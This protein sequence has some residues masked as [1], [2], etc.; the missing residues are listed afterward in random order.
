MVPVRR[1]ALFVLSSFALGAA[2]Q[3][4]GAYHYEV[5]ASGQPPVSKDGPLSVG[6]SRQISERTGSYIVNGHVGAAPAQAA[7]SVSLSSSVQ[8]NA[9]VTASSRSNLDLKPPGDLATVAGGAVELSFELRGTLEGTATVGGRAKVELLT[10]ES[11]DS[12]EANCALS[13][14]PGKDSRVCILSLKLPTNFTEKDLVLVTPELTLT[15]AVSVPGGPQLSRSSTGDDLFQ[16]ISFR[17]LNASGTQVTGFTLKGG[18]R[19]IDEAKPNSGNLAVAVEYY[20]PD[21]GLYFVT[22]NAEEIA[23]LDSGKTRGWQRS[24]LAFNVYTSAGPG[25]VAVCRFYGVFGNKSSHFYGLRGSEC[26]AL[27]G[28]S[29]WHY[30]ADVFY[31]SLPEARGDCA[32]GSVPVYRL[33]NNG[34]GGA[35]NHRYTTDL[36][37]SMHMT[38]VGWTREGSGIGVVMC[39]PT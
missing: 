36:Q 10:L 20:H 2:P 34:Q 26:E 15:V 27:L 31:A 7:A 30:E 16:M 8:A 12:K 19:S 17:V 28:D 22:A 9:S 3:A 5:T 24:G 38:A 11:T 32:N 23:D 29:V 14:Q 13:D 18:G 33:Y 4:W 35:P 1:F 21:Y 6:S 25:L 37:T 39:S